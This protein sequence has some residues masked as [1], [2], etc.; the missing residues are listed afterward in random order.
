M[1]V[2]MIW[3]RSR[4]RS[5]DAYAVSGLGN[6]NNAVSGAWMLMLMLMLLVRGIMLML[7]QVRGRGK[8]SRRH[9]LSFHGLAEGVE[10]T[11]ASF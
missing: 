8:R 9:G 4:G 3:W 5:V 11:V 2:W 10:E 6:H 1:R 7:F